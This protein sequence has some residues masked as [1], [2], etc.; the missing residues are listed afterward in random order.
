[1]HRSSAGLMQ[2]TTALTLVFAMLLALIPQFTLPISA[3]D[4]VT[5][6]SSGAVYLD[7]EYNDQTVYIKDGVFSVTVNGAQNVNLIFGERTADG[8]NGVTIDRRHVT[9]D[10]DLANGQTIEN[11]YMVSQELGAEV[12]AQTCPLLITGGSTVTATFHGE[13]RFY[14]G[15]NGGTVNSSNI[16]TAS[17]TGCG[18][19]GIQVDSGSSL[20]IDGADD[21]QV[22]GGH[23]FAIPGDDGKVTIN[24]QEV[25]YS[26]VLRANA[27]VGEYI[28]PGIGLYGAPANAS[29]NSKS[30]GAGIGGGPSLAD[31]TSSSEDFINGAP[32]T[33]I[34]NGGKVE[35]F[36]G[37]QAAGIGGAVNCAASTGMI[38]INGGEITAHGGRWAAAIGDG[39]TVQHETSDTFRDASTVIEINGGTVYAYG[40]VAA[41]G[42]GTSDQISHS[43]G[44]DADFVRQL[45][46]NLNGGT[47]RAFSGFPDGYQGG[48]FPS[49]APAAIGAGVATL[50]NKNSIYV[51]SNA[52]LRSGGFG[53]YALSEDGQNA[54]TV[55]TI[56]VDSDGYLLL[57]Q[58][59]DYYSGETRTLKVYKP[60]TENMNVD[61]DGDNVLDTEVEAYIYTTQ[62]T[63]S[64][65]HPK[66]YMVTTQDENGVESTILFGEDGKR[67]NDVEN[68]TLYVDENSTELTELRIEFPYYFRSIALTLPHPEEHGGLY[69]LAVPTHGIDAGTDVPH[70]DADIILTIDAREQ[71]TQNGTIVFPNENNLSSRPVSASLID[72]DIDGNGSTDG[73]IGAGFYPTVYGYTVYAEPGTTEVDLYLAFGTK[74]GTTYELVFNSG[75]DSDT[76]VGDGNI[77]E[78]TRTGIPL[79]GDETVLRVQKK[80]VDGETN[81]DPISYKITIIRKGDFS[82]QLTDPSKVYDG[83]PAAAEATAVGQYPLIYKAVD[84]PGETGSTTVT[85]QAVTKNYTGSA[86][87]DNS[88]YYYYYYAA[89]LSYKVHIIPSGNYIYYVLTFD[90]RTSASGTISNNTTKYA[91]I[92]Y[93]E[94]NTEGDVAYYDESEDSKVPADVS[95][96]ISSYIRI[97]KTGSTILA[98]GYSTDLTLQVTATRATLLRG[99]DDVGTLLTIGTPTTTSIPTN[100]TS[101][102][103][104]ASAK[105]AIAGG[106][107][108]GRFD[109]ETSTTTGLSQPI[110][111]G[112]F[113]WQQNTTTT[114]PD[115]PDSITYQISGT[116]TCT[117]KGYWSIAGEPDTSQIFTPI[118]VPPE[119]LELVEYTYYQT[120]NELGAAITEK[121][122]TEPTDAGRYRVEANLR[123][124]TYN[125]SGEGTFTISQR[126]L[127]VL[128]IENWLAYVTQAPTGN[129]IP[130]TNPGYIEL[131]NV[132]TGDNVT[133][134]VETGNV[135]YDDPDSNTLAV[136]YRSDKIVLAQG[137]LVG[138]EAHNYR[139]DYEDPSLIRVY[140]QLAYKIDGA[141]FRNDGSDWR[142]YYPVTSID[143][144][145]ST[146]ADY[147]SPVEESGV[148]L[149]HAEYIRARTVNAGAD[150]ARYC[151]DIEYG[152]MAFGFYRSSWDVNKLEYIELKDSHWTGMDGTNNQL[153]IVNYSNRT[154]HY[155]L[156]LTRNPTY[157]GKIGFAIK[158]TNDQ[159][160]GTSLVSL[161][162]NGGNEATGTAQTVAAAAAGAT[163][164]EAGTAA[165]A[166]SYVI[167]SDVPQFADGFQYAVGSIG[168][169]FS[170]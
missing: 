80:D 82:L 2:R 44:I 151:I 24:D 160:G 60:Q 94:Q 148:Y 110:M 108:F 133:L 169:S 17:A 22:F 9:G 87:I 59:A 23:Q 98:T 89:N 168:I 134:S 27:S 103:A 43:D 143:P 46:I 6:F 159:T 55:P 78:V 154:I 142:K 70:G 146:T 35:A 28:N 41:S 129:H 101:A 88:Y 51:S 68:L 150:E 34:I 13:C 163:P 12:T 138:G 52:D 3:A 124:L 40:G 47:I 104:E 53:H 4:L 26:D 125:A 15:T 76:I 56:A 19:A 81:P 102:D 164:G 109:Y 16:Y 73:L 115:T 141:I 147:H 114:T 119:D 112:K 29:S 128:R 137:T 153:T 58:T 64:S 69:A 117:A 84:H 127:K 72:L 156:T 57:L 107:T 50:M 139:L 20:T 91:A 85:P 86:Y 39:D 155:T 145:N 96:A 37:H 122:V 165:K 161:A 90:E 105:A 30:G 95:A 136:D 65:D 14:A 158:T 106:A 62:S 116:T 36:G 123:T 149:S 170:P 61:L 93:I 45:Q 167:L 144:V 74:A 48:E 54:E 38:Q 7:E 140:G 75:E 42:I 118:S 92:W 99:S 113:T 21:L 33:I 132:V 111:V 162:A 31:T 131:D 135:Y 120:H 100:V 152:A 83:Q 66:Y 79:T 32:G 49:S 8:A 130:I 126:P 97:T 166:T 11:L 18:F 67:A 25:L 5:E 10:P 121:L 157:G 63:T 77:Q 1:M 71:G